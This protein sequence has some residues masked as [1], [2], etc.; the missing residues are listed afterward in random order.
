[1]HFAD[2]QAWLQQL[3]AGGQAPHRSTSLQDAPPHG[4]SGAQHLQ[5]QAMMMRMSMGPPSLADASWPLHMPH[6]VCSAERSS[7]G[8]P[9][10]PYLFGNDMARPTASAG[11]GAGAALVAPWRS[12]EPLQQYPASACLPTSAI[13]FAKAYDTSPFSSWSCPLPGV[14]ATAPE[15]VPGTASN[16]GQ[17][18]GVGWPRSLAAQLPLMSLPYTYRAE[19]SATAAGVSTAARPF[20]GYPLL[21]LGPDGDDELDKLLITLEGPS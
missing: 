14:G 1:M 17:V 4:L 21:G 5:M 7:V 8:E 20:T 2:S 6:H 10:S 18:G 16:A 12:I 15:P 13:S 9:Q 19:V 3:A 11:P